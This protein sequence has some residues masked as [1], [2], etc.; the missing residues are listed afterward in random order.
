[1]QIQEILVWADYYRSMLK[2]IRMG[3]DKDEIELH[4][5]IFRTVHPE[6]KAT[7]RSFTQGILKRKDI[8]RGWCEN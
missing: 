8:M 5:K 7:K 3:F 2:D 4:K 1:M 6:L